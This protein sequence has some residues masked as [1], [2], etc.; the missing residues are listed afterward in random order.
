[1]L[2]QIY[3]DIDKEKSLEE[4]YP[5]LNV[6][7]DSKKRFYSYWHQINEVIS[8]KPIKV[9]EIGVGN[10]FV[11]RYLREKGVN[12]TTL[13]IVHDLKPNVAGSVLE[14]PFADETFDVVSCY[15]VL[16]HL[17]YSDFREALGEIQRVS[18]RCVILSLPDVTTSYR[19]YLK[20]PRFENQSGN[21]FY[22]HSHGQVLMN[23]MVST[24]GK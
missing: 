11:T 5:Y 23:M 20:L 12:V 4:H 10:G 21:S 14:I 3:K 1:M 15:E 9:L 24:I 2:S 18:Q 17:P 19:I 8:I 6:R 16:E 22:I 7:Y 13:D